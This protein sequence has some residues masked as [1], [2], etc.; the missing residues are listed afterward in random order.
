[1]IRLQNAQ[2][3]YVALIAVLVIGAASVATA[4]ALLIS[5]ADTSKSNTVTQ[6]SVQAR[7][8]ASGCAEEALG[9]IQTNS[10]YTGSGNLTLG[11]GTCSYTVTSTGS[12]TRVIDTSGIV[13]GVVRKSKVYA[14]IGGSSISITSWQEVSDS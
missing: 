11:A 2:H 9:Q 1:M 7:N 6:A 5:G 3:G 8:L 10:S 12:S 13:N 14:T 4:T